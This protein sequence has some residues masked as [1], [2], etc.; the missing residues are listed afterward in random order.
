MAPV[1]RLAMRVKK[2]R[3]AKGMTQEALAAKARISRV[4]LA[5]IERHRQDPAVSIVVRIAKALG[6]KVGELL[7]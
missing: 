4:Y 3:E 6:V 7:D 1:K 5:Q 2:L